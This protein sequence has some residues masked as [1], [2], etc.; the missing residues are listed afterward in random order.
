[1]PILRVVSAENSF[2]V[3]AGNRLTGTRSS[4]IFSARTVGTWCL[5]RTRDHDKL[6]EK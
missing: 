6:D 5:Q 1:M 3:I 2:P 4:F